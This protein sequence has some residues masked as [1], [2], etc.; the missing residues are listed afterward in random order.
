[1]RSRR[2]ILI[3]V[4]LIAAMLP[5]AAA[6]GDPMTIDGEETMNPFSRLLDFLEIV[7]IGVG[8]GILVSSKFFIDVV[9]AYYRSDTSSDTVKKVV[10]R[11]VLVVMIVISATAAVHYV[12]GI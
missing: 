11:L 4:I 12:A 1:M 7:F 6:W 5:L 3:A 9:K 2:F 8:A 10:L